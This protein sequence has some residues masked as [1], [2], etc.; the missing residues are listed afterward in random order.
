[1][2]RYTA[3]IAAAILLTAGLVAQ[4][5]KVPDRRLIQSGTGTATATINGTLATSVTSTCTTA[6]ITEEELWTYSLPANT[7]SADGKAIRV[8][9][10]LSTAA[11]VNLKTIK[12]YFGST[13]VLNS[14]A[15]AMNS[16]NAALVGVVFRTAASAQSAHVV[17]TSSDTSAGILANMGGT[18]NR[19]T[20][21]EDTTAAITM[22]VTGQNGT[23][24]ASDLCLRG[25]VVE[26]IK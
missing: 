11:N 16:R 2:R 9:A 13:V 12:M 18:Q 3:L 15:N 21:A 10:Y 22:K 19:T 8:T 6:V 7:L 20:P 5:Q 24:S 23:A 4:V 25:V 17:A 14:G 26:T 1:M